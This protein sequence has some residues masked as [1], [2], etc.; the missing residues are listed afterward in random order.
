MKFYKSKCWVLHFGHNSPRQCYRPGADWLQDCV[1][2]KDRGVLVNTWLNMGQWCA[3]VA[4][5]ANGFL[6]FMRNSAASRSREVVVSLYSALVRPHCIQFYT[7]C[8]KKNTE[9][10]EHVQR[11]A[12]KL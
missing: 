5:K 3:L 2:E 9:A 8:Y 11:R 1:Q 6:S 4:K 7:P 10:L 12:A